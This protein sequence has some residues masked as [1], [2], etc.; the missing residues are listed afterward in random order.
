M[1]TWAGTIGTTANMTIAAG[2]PEL[3]LT[4]G[5]VRAAAMIVSA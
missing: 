4:P 2:R 1:T 5:G 3:G